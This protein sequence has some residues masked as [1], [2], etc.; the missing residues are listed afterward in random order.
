MEFVALLIVFAALLWLG[1]GNLFDHRLAHDSPWGYFASDSVH[2]LYL[3][4]HLFDSGNWRY[5]PAHINAG[6]NNT[7]NYVLPI[8]AHLNV[9]LA[10][11]SGLNV[12]DSLIFI[13]VFL[14]CLA[15][16]LMYLIVRQW[17]HSVAFFSIPL[18]VFLFIK[19]FYIAITWGQ[20]TLVAGVFF[21][22]ACV[23]ALC[24]IDVPR[25]FIIFGV[26]IGALFMAHTSEFF[27]LAGLLIVYFVLQF[28][29]D[30]LVLLPKFRPLF[31]SA[32][33]FLVVTGY[34]LVIFK[35]TYL[36]NYGPSS[37]RLFS[38]VMGAGFRV[39][40]MADFGLPV[41]IMLL[42]GALVALYLTAIKKNISLALLLG[43]FMMCIGYLNYIGIGN[44]A[45]Q[46]RFF[47]PVYLSVLFGL[48]LYQVQLIFAKR[49]SHLNIVVVAMLVMFGFVYW[50]Y[51]PIADQGLLNQDHWDSF[52]WI[53]QNAES[54]ARVY[55]FYGDTYDQ[56]AQLLLSGRL[57]TYAV[58]DKLVENAKKSFVP[59]I[60]ASRNLVI[61]D[62]NLA[63]RRS[64]FSFGYYSRERNI[65]NFYDADICS[66]DYYVLDKSSGYAPALAQY[67]LA[68][69]KLLMDSGFF[70]EVYSNPLVS[71]LKNNNPGGACID[72]A[73]VRLA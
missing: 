1:V 33:I 66:F 6:Y 19:N 49:L 24:F 13:A 72:G 55:F 25:F 62:S 21:F 34:Y 67:N 5:S 27:F 52:G 31:F 18:F 53:R 58:V 41:V 9:N 38:P 28:F 63:Y 47:W 3:N 2:N 30:R 39:A 50:Q 60:F 45:F 7:V 46:V 57:V 35:S 14:A 36:I 8:L 44:R 69:R 65:T 26:L 23:L 71:I 59:R 37:Y 64:F 4:Q 16:L 15:A 10:Y 42:I 32:L 68:A 70:E 17:N 29:R 51:N 22:L 20:L 40:Q 56:N 48:A 61:Q 12:Y 43:V 73:G 54:D 11:A